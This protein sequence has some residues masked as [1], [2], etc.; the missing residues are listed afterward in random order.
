M[1]WNKKEEA[2]MT[3][4]EKY[5]QIFKKI[6]RKTDEGIKGLKYQGIPTWDSVGHMDLMAELE[7]AFE[8]RMETPDVL[9]FTSYEKG[10]KILAKYGVEIEDEN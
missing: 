9:D 8:I 10:K 1:N 7:E 2:E 3:N 4:L 5:N 6:F